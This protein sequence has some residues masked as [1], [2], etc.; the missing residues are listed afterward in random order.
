[1]RMGKV[2]AVIQAR[3]GSKRLPNKM[4]LN[5]NGFPLVEWVVERVLKCSLIDEVVIA[6]PSDKENDLLDFVLTQ[7]KYK[8]FR[9]RHLDVYDRIL[10]AAT[11]SQAQFI[12]RVCGDNPLVSWE[13][14]DYLVK[15]FLEGDEDY[16]YNHIPLHNSCP[17]GLGAEII[18]YELYSSFGDNELSEA[19]REH[20]FNYLWDNK[21]KFKISTLDPQEEAHRRPDMKLDI[22]SFKDFEKIVRMNLSIFSDRDEIVNRYRA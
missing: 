22:D 17:D 6:I 15:S 3:L 19:Q 21:E 20:C 4:L 8:V 18:S 13:E 2:V 7:K 1:M 12:V 14:I 11:D 16:M 10:R 9:G 5:M